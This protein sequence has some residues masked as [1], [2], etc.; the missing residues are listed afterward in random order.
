M[1]RTN[2]HPYLAVTLLLFSGVFAPPVLAQPCSPGIHQV[3]E[4]KFKLKNLTLREENGEGGNIISEACQLWPDN[5]N[6]TA[7]VIAYDDGTDDQKILLVAI[8]DTKSKQAVS[9]YK[10]VVEEDPVLKVGNN[11]LKLD[12][13]RYQLSPDVRAFGVRFA[14]DG[15][16][17]SAADFYF[18]N[19]LTL[20]VPVKETLRPVLV[21]SMSM[22]RTLQDS[23]SLRDARITEDA[24]ITLSIGD[25]QHNGFS[26]LV[27]SA[28]IKV[29][30]NDGSTTANNAPLS[31]EEKK[32]KNR[33]E[34]Y[35]L[36]YNGKAYETAKSGK[37]WLGDY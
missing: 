15:I 36:H 28:K 35:T 21:L 17:P 37:W 19:E 14:S 29:F 23:A 25:T 1:R 26:D 2:C 34:H 13:A 10:S 30:H 4:K 9:N 22:A 20:Y 5:P 7:S 11:S 6:W 3:L 16:M 24:T 32:A 33:T 12:M 18:G 8:I 27:A 31:A